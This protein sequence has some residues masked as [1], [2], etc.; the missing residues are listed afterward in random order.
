M[1]HNHTGPLTKSL[2]ICVSV[3]MFT[4]CGSQ[5]DDRSFKM[6][7]YNPDEVIGFFN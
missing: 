1:F 3:V 7:N 2:F 4:A 5:M 6:N